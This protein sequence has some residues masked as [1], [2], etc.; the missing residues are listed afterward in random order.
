M[1]HIKNGKFWKTI[2]ISWYFFSQT[3]NYRDVIILPCSSEVHHKV[4]IKNSF[5]LP[6]ECFQGVASFW[7]LIGWDIGLA[8][9]H[10]SLKS[11]HRSCN[12]IGS[13]YISHGRTYRGLNHISFYSTQELVSFKHESVYNYLAGTTNAMLFSRIWINIMYMFKQNLL[14]LWIIFPKP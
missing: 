4:P 3:C 9:R 12:L 7:H 6:V 5:W 13:P 1:K 14:N 11:Q 10:S 8:F 2:K